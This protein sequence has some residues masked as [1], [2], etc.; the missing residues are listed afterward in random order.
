M[1]AL[2]HFKDDKSDKIWGWTNTDDGAI[3]FWGRTRG[4]LSFKHYDSVLDAE[5]Q[6]YKKQRKGYR[7][8]ADKLDLLP[9]DW[10]GQFM[11]AKLGQ[12]KF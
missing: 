2:Y 1:I 7:Y 9:E 3:S 8:V 5:D 10:K 6:A 12:T 4:S 11:I